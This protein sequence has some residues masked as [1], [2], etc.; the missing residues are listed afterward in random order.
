MPIAD[1]LKLHFQVVIEGS[2]TQ[3]VLSTSQTRNVFYYRR[4][5]VGAGLDYAQL[6]TTLLA[7]W[8][9]NLLL[10]TSVKWSFD[11]LTVRNVDDNTDAGSF[12]A[13]GGVGAIAGDALPAFNAMLISKKTALRGKSY[14]GRFYIPGV[15]ESGQADA[16]LTGGQL[17]LLQNLASDLDDTITT[18]AGITY[19]PYLLS[20]RLS[21]LTIIPATIVGADLVSCIASDAIASMVSRKV[22]V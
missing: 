19:K 16:V 1:N 21:N 4:T 18:A 20:T 10:A 17:T 14:R 2:M 7:K 8:Q 11:R 15:P 22:R 3:G 13:G 12:T 5:N 6:M 9:A